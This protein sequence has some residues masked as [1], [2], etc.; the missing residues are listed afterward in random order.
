VSPPLIS[1]FIAI[2]VRKNGAGC[3]SYL[4]TGVDGLIG[5]GYQPGSWEFIAGV[6][7]LPP[8]AYYRGQP[9]RRTH[10]R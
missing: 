3:S 4:A 5:Q 10:H 9:R 6:R 7:E 1:V 2:R 8:P